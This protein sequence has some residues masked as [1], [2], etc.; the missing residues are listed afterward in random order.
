MS[1][2]YRI[3]FLDYEKRVYAKTKPV[4]IIVGPF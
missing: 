2:L 1:G 4:N 3:K